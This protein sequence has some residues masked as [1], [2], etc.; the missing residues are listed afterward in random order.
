MKELHHLQDFFGLEFGLVGRR[1]ALERGRICGRR[2]RRRRL[3]W[4]GGEKGMNK[5][6]KD[7]RE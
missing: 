2:R 1:G 6:G 4:K 5:S 7:L 3:G